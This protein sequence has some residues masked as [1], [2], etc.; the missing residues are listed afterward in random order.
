MKK[1]VLDIE[2][3]NTFQQVGKNEPKL[4]D[5]SLLVVYDYQT[6]QYFTFLEN[7]LNKLWPLLENTD[8]IIGYNSDYFDIPILNKYYP[9]DLTKIKS[10]DLLEE[11]RKSLG[12]K[13]RLDS[14]ADGTLGIKKSGNGLDAITWYKNG[15]IEKIKQ[16]C[17]QDV[18]ITKEIYEFALNNKFL[19]YKILDEIKQF[20]IETAAWEEKKET[21]INLTMPW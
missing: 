15:E 21:T 19:R 10:L 6:D 18:K 9:G 11:I 16:Y 7:E 3:K 12:H 8:L 1:V 20:P 4:L 5:I 2:T 13:I 17:Q 14:V